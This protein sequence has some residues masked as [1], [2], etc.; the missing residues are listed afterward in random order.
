MA[1]FGSK[2]NTDQKKRVEAKKETAPTVVSEKNNVIDLSHVIVRPRITEKA[3]VG[4]EKS[5]YT[6]DV[7][8]RSTKATIAAA[9]K[10]L[11]NVTPIKVAVVAIPSKE[12]FIRGKW[13]VKKGGKKAYV[14]LKKGETI[15]FV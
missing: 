6:F 15:E 4:A 10:E 13:G 11:Y 3:S 2:K 1:I 14:Y 9:V 7:S 8:K 12:V 5:V